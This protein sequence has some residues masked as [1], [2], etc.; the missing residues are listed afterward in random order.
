RPRPAGLGARR[1]GPARHPPHAARRRAGGLQA[2]RR[3]RSTQDRPHAL[4]RPVM[5][6]TEIADP[7][8]E[9]LAADEH[10]LLIGGERVAAADGRTF[11]TP[12]PAT[13]E[14]LATVSHGGPADVDKAVQAARA[15]FK[16]GSD[17][18][19]MTPLDRG[20]CLA[21]LAA[22]LDQ[23]GDELA[24]LESLDNGKPVKFA[25]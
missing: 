4:R 20:R 5:A 19:R 7:V 22:L 1:P 18:R 8:R 23:H 10:Q 12:D 24:Q 25:R 15:A 11:D 2:L 6:A 14:R 16:E 17:W 13:G 9:F 21:R 3:P